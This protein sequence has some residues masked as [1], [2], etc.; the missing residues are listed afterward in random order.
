MTYNDAWVKADRT[1]CAWIGANGL[2]ITNDIYIEYK[3]DSYAFTGEGRQVL[4]R[5]QCVEKFPLLAN[6]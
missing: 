3:P 6:E 5:A 4:K 2:A 1:K